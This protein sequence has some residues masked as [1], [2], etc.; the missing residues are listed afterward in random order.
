MATFKPGLVHAPVTPFKA[1]H[2][3][4]YETYSKLIEFHLK[5]GAEAIAAPMPA[6][7]DMSLKDDEQGVL[8]DFIIK[9]VKGRVP[10][11][12]HVS[13]AGTTIAVE[14]AKQAAK[15]GAAAI[16]SHPPYFWHPKA[17]MVTEHLVQIGNATK[18]PYFLCSPPVEDVGT[19]LTT[20][21]TLDV[22][23]RVPT[24]Q[25]VVDATMDFVIMVETVSLGRAKRPEFQLLSATD[26]MVTNGV[27]GGMGVFSP[28]SAVA[29]KLVKQV[30]E[31]CVKQQF[32]QAREGQE[33][34]AELA[35]CLKLAG[36][37]GLKG[38]MRAMGR[39]CGRPRPP[40]RA[41]TG[42]EQTKLA[43]DLQAMKFL[44]AEPRGW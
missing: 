11:I 30:Y 40:S 23:D 14:R 18:L 5:N 7:E 26:Y 41:L 35:H 22:I 6:G 19:P 27:I 24:L 43:A 10:V 13:D 32:T 17:S 3:I 8:L 16:V 9:Q 39:D 21:I 1:D 34:I 31:L 36:L 42:A 4:D 15:A 2:S 29:P 20:E 37:A 25:G 28:L 33:N 44:Q 12:A 38:A